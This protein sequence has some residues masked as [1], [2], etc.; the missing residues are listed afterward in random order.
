MLFNSRRYPPTAALSYVR[1]CGCA[2]SAANSSPPCC[3]AEACE[4]HL[5]DCGGLLRWR[6][7]F[8]QLW[9]PAAPPCSL[10]YAF[11]RE[12]KL[13]ENDSLYSGCSRC[14]Q[15]IIKN[16]ELESLVSTPSPNPNGGIGDSNIEPD[17]IVK[18]FEE[19]INH[20]LENKLQQYKPD[21]G[22]EQVQEV[23]VLRQVHSK[24]HHVH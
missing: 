17:I 4:P 13:I 19:T 24:G 21:L 20:T 10:E 2:C 11:E 5:N 15:P 8:E 6:G 12:D 23:H 7:P 14:S 16:R 1:S 22:V 9:W 18:H 3:A